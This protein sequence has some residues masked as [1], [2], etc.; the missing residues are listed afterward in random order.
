MFEKPGH[1]CL[2]IRVFWWGAHFTDFT[3]LKDSMS[4]SRNKWLGA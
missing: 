3:Y 1:I 4:T 2:K